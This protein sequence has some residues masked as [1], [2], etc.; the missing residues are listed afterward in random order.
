MA[1]MMMHLDGS[2]HRWFGLDGPQ[3]DLL[4]VLDDA[5]SEVYALH[6]VEQ[7]STETCMAVLRET[8]EKKG[9][10]CELYT[11]RGSHFCFTPEAGGKPDK[12][13]KTQLGRAMEQLDIRLILGH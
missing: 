1:G 12:K 3:L 4:A 5:T 11:D 13:V 9:L 2:T 8:I 6:L 7:E 10:F